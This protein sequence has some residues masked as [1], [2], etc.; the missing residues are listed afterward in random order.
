MTRLP[1]LALG[2][3]LLL[4]PMARAQPADASHDDSFSKEGLF[5]ANVAA[6]TDTEL[7]AQPDLPLAPNHNMLWCATLQLAWNE[8]IGLV[9]EKLHFTRPSPVADL[10]NREDF[11]RKDLDPGSY[12]AVAD[13]ERNHVEAEIRA[14]LEQ[15]FHGEASPELIP[16]VPRNPGPDDF[17]AYAYLYKNLAFAVPFADMGPLD[18]NGREVKSFGFNQESRLPDGARAQ[19]SICDYQ[20]PQDFIIELK[21]KAANDELILAKV[22][23]GATLQATIQAVL[24]RISVHPAS[25]IEPGDEMEVPKLNFDLRRDFSELEGLVLQP[26]P[27]AKIKNRLV[28]TKAEQ[29]VRFQLN[30]KGAILKSEAVIAFR[31]TAMRAGHLLIFNG[32]F[33]I[34]MKQKS[35]A[36]PYFALWM[37]NPTLLVPATGT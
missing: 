21:T 29:L 19:V 9:G 17:V 37:A 36:Q 2:L 26:G 13:F 10:L 14:A 1:A 24:A 23:P 16:E 31:A 12:V 15:T 3:V 20:S 7:V 5:K 27:A 35:A 33:L 4:P 32:P 28:I 6:L 25:F 18:F 30:E 34:L 8:A 22:A 11:T